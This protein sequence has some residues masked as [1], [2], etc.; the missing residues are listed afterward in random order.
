MGVMMFQ[1][2]CS[3]DTVQISMDCFVKRFQPERY[4]LWKAGKDIGAHPEDDIS[5]IYPHSSR[6]TDKVICQPLLQQQ[7]EAY[8]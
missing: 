2:T 8:V 7:P 1:C 3:S 4:E 5:R 6:K